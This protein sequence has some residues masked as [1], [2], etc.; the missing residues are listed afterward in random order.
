MSFQR[1]AFKQINDMSNQLDDL[2]DV[3][4]DVY[5][6]IAS[7]YLQLPGLVGYWPFSAADRSSGNITDQSGNGKILTEGGDSVL[8]V[9]G[10]IP[11][12]DVDGVGDRF[13]RADESDFDISGT[14]THI[15]PAIQ[16]LTMGG[17]VY[18]S[19]T[20]SAAEYFMAKHNSAGNRSYY[21]RRS[22]TGFLQFIVST[23]GTTEV[24]VVTT[25]TALVG[26]WFYFVGRFEPSTELAIFENSNKTTNTSSVPADIFNSNASFVIAAR[27]AGANA[28]TGRVSNCF[29]CAAYLSDAIIKNIFQL[30]KDAYGV[31]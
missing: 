24:S 1:D 28:M 23:N 4:I 19:N 16:G 8:N 17:W 6:G 22:S 27:E 31:E 20:A 14:E 26:T 30:T 11:Y 2:V 29:L 10:I 9:D 3:E 15:A 18:F 25:N 7:L 12:A 21:L 5:R 13:E